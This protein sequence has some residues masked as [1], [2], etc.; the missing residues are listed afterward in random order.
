[1]P[2]RLPRLVGLPVIAGVEQVDPAEIARRVAPAVGLDRRNSLGAMAVRMAAGLADRVGERAAGD[3]GVGREIAV[4]VVGRH[5]GDLLTRRRRLSPGPTHRVLL[6]TPHPHQ[7]RRPHPPPAAARAAAER[8]R[9]VG[10]VAIAPRGRPRRHL[11]GPGDR[12]SPG[13]SPREHG[14]VGNG[15]LFRDTRR[16][17][18]LAAV[19]R[20]DRGRA[21]V[22]HRRRRAA[23]RGRTCPHGQA[24]LVV[25]PG[26]RR[27]LERHAEALLRGRRQQG[28]RHLRHARRAH[29]TGSSASSASSRST[30]SG[31]PPPASLAPQWI[32]R[33]AAERRRGR[34]ARP[35][36]RLPAA[37]RLRPP[38]I[39]ALGLATCPASSAS[40]T[41]P[42]ARSS[43]RRKQTG[44]RVW[45][46]SEYGHCDVSRPVYLNRVLR[47]AGL[48]SVRPGPFGEILDTFGSRAFAVCDHQ[49]AHVYV[50]RPADVERA[51]EILASEPGVAR[52]LAGD[53]RSECRARS[54][55]VG[56]GRRPV[57][58]RRLVRVPVLARRPRRAGLCAHGRHPP[59]AGVRP[60]RA[61]LRPQAR[62]AEG[63]GDRAGCCR[64]KL[65][66][67]TLFDVVPLD[68]G[69]RARAA[70]ACR[71]RDPLDRP[72]LIGDG[73]APREGL[74]TTD[75]HGLVLGALGLS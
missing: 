21:I 22:R 20:P 19:Q 38:A 3:V 67:R 58:P 52:V 69:A 56:R 46:V 66:F 63:A 4:S 8:P 28:V 48:L 62:L 35:D 60:V 26:G 2:E 74:E 68:A 42:A 49:L 41:R 33:A 12:S 36:A 47:R 65:G 59:Q 23:E 39:R 37:P 50:R 6:R 51:R 1:M 11:H 9:S 18:V 32:G 10:V 75:V 16:G 31:A 7:R 72:V 61:L 30:P 70:T 27:R 5:A 57:G 25:Q 45:V 17:P 71:P 55:P 64:K 14:V 44:A 29:A 73:A 24:V 15:W 13:R 43:T 53:E 54:S 34:A 40:S